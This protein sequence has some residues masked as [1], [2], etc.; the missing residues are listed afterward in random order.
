MKLTQIT[1]MGVGL[2]G[3]SIGLAVRAVRPDCKI[4]G[5]G[6]R[7]SSLNKAEKIGAIDVA[8][9]DPARAVKG[10]DLVVLCTPVGIFEDILRQIG[11]ALTPGCIVTDVGSTKRSVVK[12]AEGILPKGVHFVGSHPIAGSEKRGVEYARTDLFRH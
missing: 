12:L 2:L 1:I 3:G 8:Q 4:V 6:H 10:S 5:F 7:A 11:P 9:T